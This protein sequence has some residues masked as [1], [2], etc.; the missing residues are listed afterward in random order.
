MQ[1]LL[2]IVAR[3]CAVL[4]LS[5]ACVAPA[6]AQT[7]PV[8]PSAV[9]SPP[10][11]AQ[12]AAQKAY[13]AKDFARAAEGFRAVA[14]A[15][16]ANAT[17]W[18]RL[19]VSL[20][21]LGQL[22]EAQ[23]DLGV[24]LARGFHPF[25]VHIRLAQ[26]AVKRHDNAGALAELGKAVAAQPTPPESLRDDESWVPL[27]GTPGFAAL[28]EK[29]DV[30]FYPCRHDA[31]YR[32]LDFWIGDWV[33]RNTAGFEMGRS[34]I[35]PALDGCA[36]VET[37]TGTF[38]GNGKS[39]TSYDAPAKRWIQHYLTSTGT[40]NDYAGQV[41]GKS[42]VMIAPSGTAAKPGRIRMSFTPLDDGRVRQ[43]METSTD[44]GATWTPGFDGYYAKR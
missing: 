24:A 2:R 29:Q 1:Q 15:E 21:M 18:Y 19:A 35:E 11:A 9:P 32:A 12:L 13:D 20:Q 25:S 4:V 44:G 22:D 14:A 43:L 38:G 8:A 26:I 41:E 7:V 40:Y 31:A 27:R 37:W 42:V 5:A 30:A 16:P 39:L 23:H 34:R 10:S 6:G 3:V 36:I 28:L 17:A 33:V